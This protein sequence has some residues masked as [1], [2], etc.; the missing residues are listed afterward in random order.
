MG[1][2]KLTEDRERLSMLLTQ[3]RLP[4][5]WS[6]A[7]LDG[8]GTIVARDADTERVVGRPGSPAL[9][10]RMAQAAEGSLESATPDGARQI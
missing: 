8:S 6:A 1:R 10:Q 4:P 2:R 5:D 3:Q 9:L 7:I